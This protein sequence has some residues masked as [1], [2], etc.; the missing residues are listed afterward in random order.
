MSW[1]LTP[2]ALRDAIVKAIK[3]GIPGLNDCGPHKGL[4]DLAA[5]KRYGASAPA[6]RVS[7]LGFGHPAQH[8]TGKW[9]LPVDLC[10]VV[11]T[12]DVPGLDRDTAASALATAITIQITDARWGFGNQVARAEQLRCHNEYAEAIDK[13]GLSVWQVLWQQAILIGDE[14]DGIIDLPI[15]PNGNGLTQILSTLWINGAPFDGSIDH[16]PPSPAPAPA[17]PEVL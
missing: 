15:D 5:L 9:V 17:L 4:F 16:L 13:E 8:S 11:I 14:I 7:I 12:R 2:Q 3:T 10:C 1:S 6:A